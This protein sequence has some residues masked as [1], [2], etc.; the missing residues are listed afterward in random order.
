MRHNTL[1]V[2]I[3]IVVALLVI[4]CQS[5]QMPA[6][7]Q[8]AT[9]TAELPRRILFIGDSFTWFLWEFP[10][11][12]TS[13]I[14]PT[15]VEVDLIWTGGAPL[16]LHWSRPSTLQAIQKGDWDVVVLQEDIVDNWRRVDQFPEYARKFHDEIRQDGAEPVFYMH[17]PWKSQAVPTI[18][19]IAG[20]YGD[21][22]TELGDKVAPVGLAW[23]RVLQERPDLDLYNDDQVHASAYGAYLT[24]CVLYATIYGQSPAGATYRMADSHP[25][26]YG[27]NIPA[28][29]QLA[30]DDAVFL[31]RIAW[32]TVVDYETKD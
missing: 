1:L 31:Q 32:E 3:L 6:F 30:D 17:W 19:Q 13:T 15:N 26:D 2:T 7:L 29:W 4:A 27:W 8:P 23:Q 11:L 10:K 20:A 16:S 5:V 22:G 14:P 28:G 25:Y 24:M 18:E 9:P 12:A 21:M